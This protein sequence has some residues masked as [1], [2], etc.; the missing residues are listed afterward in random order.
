MA[1]FQKPGSGVS[2][3]KPFRSNFFRSG[4][5]ISVLGAEPVFLPLM[6]DDVIVARFDFE[7][8]ELG[9]NDIASILLN[10]PVYGP[11]LVAELQELE[12]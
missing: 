3:M 4:D 7:N 9:R 11:A 5:L 2:R 6:N 10:K 8:Q 12:P 1:W